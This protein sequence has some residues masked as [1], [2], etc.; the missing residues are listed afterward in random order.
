MLNFSSQIF[1]L[2]M[3]NAFAPYP[4]ERI[5]SGKNSSNLSTRF[6]KTLRASSVALGISALAKENISTITL[7]Q[8]FV[9]R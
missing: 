7:L 3:L 6:S 2:F 1:A 8:Q 9:M 5:S 4:I